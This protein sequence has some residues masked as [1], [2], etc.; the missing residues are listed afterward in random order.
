MKT[1]SLLTAAACVGFL[2]LAANANAQ[3]AVVVEET[4]LT[5][6]QPVECKTHY[7][8]SWRDN[9]FIQLGA[10]VQVPF[11]ENELPDGSEKRHATMVYNLGV[12][13]WF[14]PYLGLRFN[15]LYGNKMRWDFLQR[16][17]AQ[18]ASLNFDLMWDMTSSVCGV[19]P[20][21]VFSFIPF[22]GVGGTYTWDFKGNDG[23]DWTRDLTRHRNSQWTLPVS[24]GFQLRFR[25]CKYVDFFAE[26]R[27]QFYG[28]NFNN[29]T[30]GDPIEANI[31]AIGGLS[32]N[33]GGR[34]FKAYNPCDSYGNVDAL[35]SQ[36]ND[37]RGALAA[38]T[39]ALA[40]AEAQLP[41]PDA[42][43]A[44]PAP[45]QTP[46]LSAVRFTINSDEITNEE[47]VN[48]YNVAEWLKANPNAK[49]TLCG[50][51]DKDTGTTEYNMDLSRRR[52]DAVKAALT[53]DYG[54]AAD[55]IATQAYG[56][57][58]QP[59]SENDWNRIVIFTQP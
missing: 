54:I 15:A 41:C 28:D 56:S 48:V 18:M 10:G 55:R 13:H 3:E 16:N 6:T 53:N 5:V 35:N 46:M 42:P 1:K 59:Y 29:Y 38:T 9:W 45:Q 50:Y 36:I 11:V 26:A 7:Y 43:A 19:N 22:I 33:I 25:L 20:D 2:S 37:L 21:R 34:D 49:I 8:S 57:D 51:A 17:K 23:N 31:T 58:K 4:T 12:G 44:A 30:Q 39:A 14:S 32:F 40:A 47:M 52:A 24:V 27:A